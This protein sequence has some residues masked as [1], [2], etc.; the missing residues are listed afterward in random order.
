MKKG[1]D[2]CCGVDEGTDEID[3]IG[4][5]SVYNALRNH[6]YYEAAIRR[7][8]FS[9]FKAFMKSWQQYYQSY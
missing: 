7:L 4:D 1:D 8:T 9:C 2:F 5:F 6:S 3:E